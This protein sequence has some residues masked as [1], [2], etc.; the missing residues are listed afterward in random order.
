VIFEI[1]AGATAYKRTREFENATIPDALRKDHS[2]KPGVWGLIQV[3]EGRL[4]YIVEEPHA[5]EMVLEPGK[6][7]VVLPEVLHRVEP[8][9]DVRFF[10]EF[11]RIED[12]RTSL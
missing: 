6:N 9:G 12:Q 1:P 5:C 2:T 4:R 8:L 3:L 10:V 7:G 11:Y